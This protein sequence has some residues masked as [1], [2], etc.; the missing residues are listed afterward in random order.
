MRP[1]IRFSKSIRAKVGKVKVQMWGSF[2]DRELALPRTSAQIIET[3][4]PST[5]TGKRHTIVIVL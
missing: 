5:I 3:S 2:G 4:R 1:E